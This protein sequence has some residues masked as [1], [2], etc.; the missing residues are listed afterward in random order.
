[1]REKF[2]W[3]H[4]SRN[5]GLL[6]NNF[7]FWNKSWLRSNSNDSKQI[8]VSEK[9]SFYVKTV[10]FRNIILFRKNY[11]REKLFLSPLVT[12]Q[13]LVTKQGLVMEQRFISKQ[14]ACFVTSPCYEI[15]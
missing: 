1:L 7:L 9:V 5:E 4:L 15:K 11:S 12:K 10:T 2:F 6:W 14:A 3:V 13:K 8:I